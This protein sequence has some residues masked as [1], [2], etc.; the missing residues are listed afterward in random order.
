MLGDN[1]QKQK[2]T[3]KS[4]RKRWKTV[5]FT[6]PTYV[7]YSDIDYS[8]D[9]E[10][11]E[12]LF[13]D[14]AQA[15][16]QDGDRDE[17]EDRQQQ[18]KQ[19]DQDS[20]DEQRLL[21]E[22]ASSDDEL[23]DERAKVEPLKTQSA[24]TEVKEEVQEVKV[25]SQK[26]DDDDEVE[27]RDSTELLGGGVG[28]V[29]RTRNGKIRNTDS[30]FKDET[31]ETKKI[32][33]TPNLLRDDGAA[34]PSTDSIVA[35]DSKARPS[36]EN[37]MEKEFVSDKDSKKNKK[38]KEKKEKDKKPSAI[39]SFFSRKDKKR[40]SEDDEESVGKRSMD[41][42]SEPR[43]SED[44][45]ADDQE[46]PH[47][48]PSK[49][50]KQQPRT[51]P[52]ATRK[53]STG[54]SQSKKSPEIG[55]SLSE[56]RTNNV[57][58]VPPSTMRIVD[59]ETKETRE[60][61]S[62]QQQSTRDAAQREEKPASANNMASRTI[63]S[64]N[65]APTQ[66]L[67]QARS[68]MDLEDSDSSDAAEALL[69]E[70]PPSQAPASTVAALGEK[71]VG[72][73]PHVPGAFPD[74]HQS[75]AETPTRRGL[76][77]DAP[78]DR[79]SESPVEVSPISRSD[80]SHP[81]GLVA[82]AAPSPSPDASPSPDFVGAD[83]GI[84]AEDDDVQQQTSWNDTK[85]RA[86]FDEGKHVRDLLAVVY[87]TSDVEPADSNA[88][89]LFREQNAKLAEIT[90][91]SHNPHLLLLIPSISWPGAN[92]GNSNLIT[93]LVTGL[94]ESNVCEAPCN[95]GIISVQP[96]IHVSS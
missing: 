91:V 90:T 61:P 60:V 58:N 67:S 11:I 20:K 66:N 77:P 5:T 96:Y 14:A 38:E 43:E 31:V 87:D 63:G 8:T 2:S 50:Q 41:V 33:L 29:G 49:L 56:S 94:L 7:D 80:Q 70:T 54:S 32:T 76:S 3:L 51:E 95:D 48:T 23:V 25:E 21:E 24:K 39:R 47:R 6:E 28:M 57:S 85:L 26:D 42:M 65:N 69:A 79:L 84:K 9:E 44:P 4:I 1:P 53:N 73:R 81:P 86:F 16:A 45:M 34:R 78:K 15:Q 17:D 74:S 36:L 22:Q 55:N 82:D 40:I 37:K 30:F 83:E 52:T 59:P 12:E 89:S 19:Q 64:T 75:P 27:T 35:K 92:I 88:G 18:Q 62:H 71:E 10:D 93:C 72:L 68:R 46:K 13:G